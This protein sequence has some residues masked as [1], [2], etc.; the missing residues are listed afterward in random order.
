MCSSDL[1]PSHDTKGATVTNDLLKGVGSG[2]D[3]RSRIG[4]KIKVKYIIIIIFWVTAKAPSTPS[5]EKEAS[6][7]SRYIKDAKPPLR[8]FA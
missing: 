1:F 8:A 3:A 4:N 5:K 2:T 7:S 6:I